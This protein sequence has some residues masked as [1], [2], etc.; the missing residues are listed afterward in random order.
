MAR[1]TSRA[2]EGEWP[3]DKIRPHPANARRHGEE[4]IGM[5]MQSLRRFGQAKPILVLADGTIIAGHG[6]YEAMRRLGAGTARVEVWQGSDEAARAYMLA[7]NQLATK[8]ED[9]PDAVRNILMELDRDMYGALGFDDDDLQALLSPP[10]SKGRVAEID[11]IE[12]SELDSQFWIS[13]RGPLQQQAIALDRLK[14]VME[15][16]EGV[17]VELGTIA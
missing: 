8:G 10:E 2:I 6:V 7:D 4:Q 1:K 12:V 16:L 9:D 3:L 5:I 14:Q 15:E 11:E 13:V 17:E